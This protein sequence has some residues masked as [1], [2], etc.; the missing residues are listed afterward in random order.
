MMNTILRSV[1]VRIVGVVLFAGLAG[2]VG[3]PGSN[4]TG[5]S[6]YKGDTPWNISRAEQ[7]ARP[8]H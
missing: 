1:V 5:S 4:G 2:C 6:G 8:A 3:G 7:A